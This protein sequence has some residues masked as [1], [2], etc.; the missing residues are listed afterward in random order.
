MPGERRQRRVSGSRMMHSKSR[1][2]GLK[3]D[4]VRNQL[5]MNKGFYTQTI[6]ITEKELAEIEISVSDREHCSVKSQLFIRNP[7]TFC[8]FPTISGPS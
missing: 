4:E 5:L 8:V 7:F 2:E 3:K 6:V 1:S